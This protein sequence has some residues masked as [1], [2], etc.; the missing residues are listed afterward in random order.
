MYISTIIIPPAL[1]TKDRHEVMKP[2][3]G[4][5]TNGKPNRGCLARRR[6]MAVWLTSILLLSACGLFAGNLLRQPESAVRDEARARWLVSCK[7]TGD[8]IAL[9]DDGK[10]TRFCAGLVSARGLALQGNM[11][12]CA[13]ELGVAGYRLDT[14]KR[15]FLLPIPDS[16]FLNDITAMNEDTLFV[17]DSVSNRISRVFPALHEASLF[18]SE[19][20]DVNG[21]YYDPFNKRLLA[22]T[23]ANG[24]SIC[25]ID[26]HTAVLEHLI[27]PLG[28]KGLDGLTRDAA[29]HW[30]FSS[31]QE[32]AVYRCEADFATTPVVVAEG[33]RGP[34]D[35]C[36]V[37]N[38]LAIPEFDANRVRMVSVVP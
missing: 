24:G 19:I 37:G 1:H 31:W 10:Q 3:G 21:L 32:Q 27:I 34:A 25:F 11:L 22:L 5:G 8:I 16:S 29:G 6:R 30:Y 38:T 17:S 14:A 4:D 15:T 9:N 20:P 36:V 33:L 13:C 2:T 18:S 35:I 7:Q 26:P 12:Y 23:S 28:M